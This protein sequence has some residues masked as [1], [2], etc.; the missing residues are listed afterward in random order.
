M[1]IKLIC[2]YDKYIKLPFFIHPKNSVSLPVV[3][4]FGPQIYHSQ[5]EFKSPR[6]ISALHKFVGW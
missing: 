6:K 4:Q 5:N 2:I 1:L 3:S